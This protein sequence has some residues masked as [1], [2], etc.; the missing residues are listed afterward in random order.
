[1]ENINAELIFTGNELLN[2]RI[3]NTNARW[4][5]RKLSNLGVSVN[6]IITVPDNLEMIS[7]NIKNSLVNKPTFLFLSG[8]LG[9]SFDDMTLEAVSRAI[10]RPL[11]L[12]EKAVNF[13]KINY[14]FL[15]KLKLIEDYKLDHYKMKM[16]TIPEGS[17]PLYNP[18]GAAPGVK[19][20]HEFDANLR[21]IIFCLPGVPPELKSIFRT[22][23]Q[24]MIKDKVGNTKFVKE[25][26]F[27][28]G[29]IESE[30]TY[31]SDRIMD[32]YNGLIWVK[33]FVKSPHIRKAIEFEVSSRGLEEP[34]KKIVH[35]ALSKL[36][37]YILEKNGKIIQVDQ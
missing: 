16:A 4:L 28:E 11:T 35:E 27:A 9:T 37:K 29:F 15:K 36:K 20:I 32:E 23:I 2:G 26:F 17:I 5:C 19:I 13:I 24:K 25:S 33:T 6:R 1:M 21:T 14:E 3:L 12:N 31:L 30:I 18:M 34:T 7:E 10:K 22:H 8:G